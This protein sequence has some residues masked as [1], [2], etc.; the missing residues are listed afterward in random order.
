MI[1][2]CDE[3]NEIYLKTR[4]WNG[5]GFFTNADA[6]GAAGFD[7][8][9]GSPAVAPGAAAFVSAAPDG[10]AAAERACLPAAVQGWDAAAAVSVGLPDSAGVES[11][12][13]ASA[14]HPDWVAAVPDVAVRD[15][16]G[17]ASDA[18]VG[19]VCLPAAERDAA[20]RAAAAEQQGAA[21]C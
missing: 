9:A 4:S 3:Y 18:A 8:A 16:V 14:A 21:Q 10:G 12:D 6:Q 13:E 11:P 17:M 2:S 15:V 20:A 1:G 5:L 19:Q 7:A